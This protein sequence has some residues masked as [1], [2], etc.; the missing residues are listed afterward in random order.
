MAKKSELA[1]TLLSRFKGVPNVEQEDV[2]AWIDRSLLEHGYRLDQDVRDDDQL[3]ILLYAEWD[4]ITQ[5]SLRT[6]YYF[7]Y[8]DAEE[9]VDKR[10]VSE[11]Y[12][13]LA[14]SLWKTYE[15]KKNEAGR[16]AGPRF[17]IMT[18]ADRG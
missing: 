17:T 10:M 7:E 9:S 6:A 15:R 12:R 11:T 3:L 13:N 18:R 14:D 4:G 16:T 2:E 8:K 1:E 5:I